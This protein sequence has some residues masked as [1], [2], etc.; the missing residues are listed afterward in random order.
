MKRGEE[1]VIKK[2]KTRSDKR[3]EIKPTICEELKSCI[4]RL[5]YITNTPV[6]D[7]GEILCVKG[8]KS[9][10][11]LEYLS[12]YFRRD[13]QFSNT[14]FLGDGRRESLQKRQQ[15][16]RKERISI[17]FKRDDYDDICKLA[18]ALDVTPSKA[19]ALL[20]DASVKNTNLLN[21]YVKLHL[22]KN[23]D[24]GRMRE[25]KKVINYVK[26]ENPYKEETV[27]WFTLLS[28]I[29]DDIKE[30]TQNIKTRVNK[31]LEK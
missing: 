13:L 30:G 6:K 24:G 29:V 17:R 22:H 4:Y 18:Y 7:I 1:T 10:I 26:K 19:T 20:L 23:L 11:V 14:I 3:I 8:I 2:R 9:R 15:P 27:S 25:L 16:G 31:W 28:M 21:S 12:N 5:S